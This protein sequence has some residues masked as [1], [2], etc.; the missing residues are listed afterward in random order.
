[1]CKSIGINNST[2]SSVEAGIEGE[3][4]SG[5]HFEVTFETEISSNLRRLVALHA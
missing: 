1:M 2:R 5:S 4:V 3:D